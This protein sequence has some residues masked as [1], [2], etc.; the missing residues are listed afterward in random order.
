[1][2]YFIKHYDGRVTVVDSHEAAKEHRNLPDRVV[3]YRRDW[4]TML[5]ACEIADAAN[6]TV[7]KD[8]YLAIDNGD[9]VYP[10]FDVIA[11][12]QVGDEVSYAFNG[13]AY[14]CGEITAISRTLLK[15]TTSTGDTF[16]RQGQTDRWL[17]TGGTW[18]LVQGHR[19]DRN[20]SF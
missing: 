5:D 9:H 16:W 11:R 19:N 8:I 12:P 15:I 18:S 1:M 3:S 6:K 17:K 14:P 20:P 7:G 4:E 13:D 2:H 10:R